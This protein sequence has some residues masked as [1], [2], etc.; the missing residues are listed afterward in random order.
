[1][2]KHPIR[3]LRRRTPSPLP[4]DPKTP[5]AG[6]PASPRRSR[7]GHSR[8]NGRAVVGGLLVTV[9]AV[10]VF[11]AY[12]RADAG[13]GQ[14]AVAVR[15][16]LPVGHRL[17]PDDL[18]VEPVALPP[19]TADATFTA[20]EQ[21][22]GAITLAPLEDDELVQRSAVRTDGAALPAG[23]EFSFPVDR[24]R[25]VDGALKPGETVDLL[26]TYGSG[27]EA[28]TEVLARGSTVIAVQS[29]GR[30]GIGGS[31]GLV[32]TVAL[33]SADEV[34]DLAHAAQVADLTVV[35]ATRSD[36]A[37]SPPDRTATPARDIP[38]SPSATS[39]DGS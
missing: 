20:V 10:T 9:A 26:G 28:Y 36:R 16:A 13:P 29:N 14:H 12:T 4:D 24:E 6:S 35:R 19:G 3:G 33:A 30:S 32:L 8:P 27:G 23:H 31:G 34:L 5:D 2:T 18:V 39:G 22:L 37:A 17:T 21:V 1:M 15:G 11:G 38:S 25:A 7:S